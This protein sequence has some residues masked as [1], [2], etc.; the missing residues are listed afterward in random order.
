V[1]PASDVVAADTGCVVGKKDVA[2][3]AVVLCHVCSVCDQG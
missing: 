3:V 1:F 2:I